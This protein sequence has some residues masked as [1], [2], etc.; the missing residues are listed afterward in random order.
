[1]I[2]LADLAVEIEILGEMRA[3]HLITEPLFDADGKRMR[4]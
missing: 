2:V 1:M 3:A 4:G